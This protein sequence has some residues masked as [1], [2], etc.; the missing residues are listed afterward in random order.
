MLILKGMMSE[1]YIYEDMNIN[2]NNPI[3][4]D[5]KMEL[6]GNI[7][8]TAGIKAFE[9]IE[10]NGKVENTSESVIF[11]ESGDIVID[12]TNLNLNGLVYAPEGCIDI[13]EQNF[14]MRYGIKMTEKIRMVI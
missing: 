8:L 9:N 6:T 7:S 3:E 1:D 5:G 4:T 2:I 10:L 14:K 12:T 11:S 13:T